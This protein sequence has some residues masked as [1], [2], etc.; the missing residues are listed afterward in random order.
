MGQVMPQ[1]FKHPKTGVYWFRKTVPERLRPAVGRREIK[2]SLGT[3]DIR[4]A[5]LRYPEAAAR[6]DLLLQQAARGPAHLTHKQVVALAGEWYRQ[7]LKRREDRPG[8]PLVWE[9]TFSRLC[10]LRD[11]SL[12]PEYRRERE[13]RG[14]EPV[15]S[16]RLQKIYR[17]TAFLDEVKEEVDRLLASKGLIIDVD[18][19]ECLALEVYESKIQLCVTLA[20]R[21]SGDYGADEHLGELPPF[22]QLPINPGKPSGTSLS[23]LLDAWVAERRPPTGPCTN[24]AEW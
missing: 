23:S 3:K 17:D 8:D 5:K 19:H 16:R 18:S 13:E 1:P 11:E 15:Y 6:A 22:E 10:D 24:G 2:V 14:A 7:E 9:E 20:R 4:E 21:A 12:T